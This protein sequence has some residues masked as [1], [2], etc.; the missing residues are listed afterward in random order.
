MASTDRVL[1]SATIQV[2]GKDWRLVGCTVREA[3]C[4]IP[5]AHVEIGAAADEEMVEASAVIDKPVEI[6]FKRSD[7]GERFFYG[8]VIEAERFR[9]N[10]DGHHRMRMT[11]VPR[12]WKLTKR[13][14]L[15]TFTSKAWAVKDI[16]TEVLDKAGAK[17]HE[18][19]LVGDHL[20]RKYTA[21]FRETDFDFFLRLC[22]EE[23]IYFAVKHDGGKD[24]VLVSDDPTGFGDIEGT[25]NLGF[26][27]ETGFAPAPDKVRKLRETSRVKSGKVYV[28]DYNFEKPKLK[29]EGDADGKDDT[30]KDLE[31]YVY[32]ARAEDAGA[33]KKVAQ[34]LIESIQTDRKIV[35][36]EASVLTL[37]PGLRFEV[38]EHPYASLNQ[39]Y[40]VVSSVIDWHHE[41]GG[42]G[43]GDFSNARFSAIPTKN[44]AVRPTRRPVTQTCAGL[45]TAWTKGPSG[46]EINVDKHGRVKGKFHWDR[47]GKDDD[48]AS[49]WWRT[50]QLPTSQMMFNPRCNWEVTVAYVEGDV[51][52]PYCMQRL[53]NATNMPPYKLP[54]NK[55]RST[56]QTATTPGGGT[57][58]EMFR[59]DDSKGKEE[60]FMNASKDMSID[61]GNNTTEAVGANETHKIGSNHKLNVT[62]SH[63]GIV[64]GNQSI[65]VGANQKLEISSFNVDDIGGNHSKTVGGARNMKIGG[66]HKRTVSGNST[67]SVGGM[68]IDLVVGGISEST[69]AAFTSNVAAAQ[70]DI[71]VKDKSVVVGGMRTEKVGAAKIVVTKGGRGVEVKG[72]LTQMVGGAVINKVKGDKQ[73]NAGATYTEIAAGA[74]IIKADNVTYEAEV[75]LT[76]VM[77]A[78]ILMITPASVMLIGTSSKL[79]GAVVETGAMIIDN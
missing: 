47:L 54:D 20:D 71:T 3:L 43:R 17:D 39:E 29:L 19:N 40:V 60:M 12:L 41:R 77:G 14:N 23:G 1:V 28:R 6:H 65:T 57:S 62:D 22:T 61:V 46:Q 59:F 10:Q 31:V 16:L 36:G 8:T 11:V 78:S 33:A 79:D 37:K 49:D 55:T 13:A 44:N 9:T 5:V 35:E 34:R 25:K 75:M 18:I 48:T 56:I 24:I 63:T 73:E 15:R 42:G 21:Q 52:R 68:Q 32:P 51:D 2:D 38:E 66:D 70:V 72:V 26:I 30:T 76:C 45:Q 50:W 74:S 58:N 64:Q 4:E 27:H 69:P 67:L 53:Y 7:S